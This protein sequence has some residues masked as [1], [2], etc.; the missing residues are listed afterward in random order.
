MGAR[1]GSWPMRW[2][3]AEHFAA[4]RPLKE[5]GCIM[6]H[7]RRGYTNT[8]H[9]KSNQCPRRA[10]VL[11]QILKIIF[12]VGVSK[13]ATEAAGS[14]NPF[15]VTTSGNS[16]PFLRRGVDMIHM[17]EVRRVRGTPRSH[18]MLIVTLGG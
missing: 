13:G 4:G 3:R 16:L 14:T 2:R 12:V 8:G 7:G 9:L 10:T 5:K 11:W 6:R 1:E 15:S 17:Q 18:P